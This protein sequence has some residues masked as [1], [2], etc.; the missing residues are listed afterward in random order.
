MDASTLALPSPSAPIQR[1][2]RGASLDELPQLWNAVRSE[3]SLVGPRPLLMEYLLLQRSADTNGL[4]KAVDLLEE[5]LDLKRPL[6][7][8]PGR[9]AHAVC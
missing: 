9:C 2:S 8:K 3:M 1:L 5:A 6:E 4:E 7:Q